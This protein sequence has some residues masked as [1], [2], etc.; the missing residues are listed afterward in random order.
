VIIDSKLKPGVLNYGELIL[1]GNSKKNYSYLLN[2]CHPFLANNKRNV[3][4]EK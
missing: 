1:P 3:K 4:I 2:I